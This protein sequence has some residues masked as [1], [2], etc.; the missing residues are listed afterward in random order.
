MLKTIT[1][2][3]ELLAD[4]AQQLGYIVFVSGKLRVDAEYHAQGVMWYLNERRS[5]EQQVRLA[6]EKARAARRAEHPA[7]A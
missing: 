5:T 1:E 6:L 2:T 3:I 7:L 4:Q